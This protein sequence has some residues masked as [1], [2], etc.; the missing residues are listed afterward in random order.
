MDVTA[1]TRSHEF[2]YQGGRLDE[3]AFVPPPIPRGKT[4]KGCL[5]VLLDVDGKASEATAEWARQ[6]LIDA[7]YRDPSGSVTSALRRAIEQVNDELFRENE[8][9]IRPER[10]YATLA[11]SVVRG[12]DLFLALVGRA[13]GYVAQNERCE[14]LGRG[15]PRPGERPIDLLGQVDDVAIEMFYRAADAVS[16]LV[17]ASSGMTDLAAGK[18]ERLLAAPAPDVVTGI[19]HLIQEHQGRRPFRSLVIELDRVA[20]PTTE[21]VPLPRPASRSLGRAARPDLASSPRRQS[22]FAVPPRRVALP[23]EPL[24]AERS[25]ELPRGSERT[26]RQHLAPEPAATLAVPASGRALTNSYRVTRKA[27]SSLPLADPSDENVIQRDRARDREESALPPVD[28]PD[29]GVTLEPIERPAR[30]FR[31]ERRPRRSLGA[32]QTLRPV[33]LALLVVALFFAGYGLVVI[34]ARLLQD[35]AAYASAIATL[36][37]AEQTEREALAQNDPLARQQL[38]DEASRLAGQAA[39]SRLGSPAMATVVARIRHEDEEA[40]GAVPLSPP[41]QIVELPTPGDQL[42]LRGTD[43]SVLDRTN[44]RVYVYLL[45]VDGTAARSSA[46]PLLVQRG[47]RVG[48]FTVGTLGAIAALPPSG[49]RT[50]PT[51]LVLDRAG[52]LLRYEPTRGLTASP[53]RDP[54]AWAQVSALAGSAGRLFALDAVHHTLTWSP[55]PP[56]GDDSSVNASFVSS[57]EVDLSDVVDVAVDDD[58]FLLHAS[59]RVEKFTDGHPT[60][61]AGPPSELA[62]RRPVGLALSAEAVFVGDPDRGRIVELGRDGTYRRTLSDGEGGAILTSLRSLALSDDARSLY[63][64]TGRTVYRF[65][66]P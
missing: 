51:L 2:W 54:A 33:G 24:A 48:P 50:T 41:E 59:G 30:P 62:P 55:L 9:S 65:P 7:Y 6:A 16:A 12:D 1:L 52:V 66:L 39:A 46:N 32:R 15:D 47:D 29:E 4:S 44:S 14:R 3:V 60:R 37:Q 58:L 27:E 10:H 49:A 25:A 22:P 63:V 20:A 23:D 35:A 11:C 43:L 56:T 13:V 26:V 31:R 45:N 36:A 53:V 57:T 64:L 17:L 19:R 34:P 61:F 42:T 8:R 38:L 18:I 5:F 21:P 40:I 28:P